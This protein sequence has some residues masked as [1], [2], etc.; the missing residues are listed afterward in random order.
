MKKADNN[1][2]KFVPYM[3]TEQIITTNFVY[4]CNL[5]TMSEMSIR[6]NNIMYLVVNGKGRL[7][8]E[9][10]K[11]ELESGMIFFTFSGAPFRIENTDN[12]S[13]MYITFRGQRSKKLF[14]RFMI[15]PAN[16]VFEGH[17]GLISYWHNCI[18]K[19]NEQNIDL[20]SESVL[21]YTF[22]QMSSV[23]ENNENTLIG[24]ILKY[25]EENF[26]NSELTLESTADALG[27]NSKYISKLFKNKI[28][29]TFSEYL[30]N[31][32]IQHAVFL[33]ERGITA[34]KN[35]ALL[36]GYSDPFY[37]SNVF[38]KNMGISPSE[39]IKKK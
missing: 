1:I 36:S 34:V 11:H 32:R 17:E 16:C 9:F 21:L 38:K 4:E 33:M 2:C 31:T 35:V 29:I 13:Y 28:G 39:Y 3:E 15:T 30:K 25:I 10:M 8:T 5:E 37:F 7:C 14:E 20:I 22:S 27:Y 6:Q 19:A 26:S 12:I 18:G 23:P 24:D